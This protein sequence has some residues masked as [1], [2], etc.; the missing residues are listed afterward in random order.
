MDSLIKLTAENSCLYYSLAFINCAIGVLTCVLASVI[1]T[2]KLPERR[3]I[4]GFLSAA[5]CAAAAW[6]RVNMSF[7]E[8]DFLYTFG[9]IL[10]FLL[11]FICIFAFYPGKKCF[12]PFLAAAGLIFTDALKYIV[13]MFLSYDYFDNSDITEL[14][15]ELSIGTA[16]LIVVFAVFARRTKKTNAG[17]FAVKPDVPLYILVLLSVSVFIATLIFFG[18]N[19]SEKTRFSFLLALLNI[20]LVGSTVLYA[21]SKMFR[22]RLAEENYR[23]RLDMQRRHFSQMEKK[24][25]ELRVFRHDFPKKLRPAVMYLSDG[26]TAAAMDILSEFT[27]QI[28]ASR[29]R[30][31]TGNFMLDT[32]LECQQQLAEKSGCSITLAS[33]SIFPP[34]GIEPDD[35][36]TIFPNALDNAIE[37][38]ERQSGGGEIVFASRIAEDTVYVS[39][40]NPCSSSINRN[41]QLETTKAD[42]SIHGLGIK[43]I[44]K[45]AAKYG[46]DNV[47]YFTKDGQFVLRIT[48][49]YKKT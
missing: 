32:V 31:N 12:K 1:V 19:Y 27:K 3:L 6:V 16:V 28:E 17:I 14:F 38:C 21:V 35:I 11:N 5:L 46:A 36:Y 33:G 37:E 26:N 8:A 7:N 4:P 2:K 24:N 10:L 23:R 30:F 42:K 25:E 34:E 39:I 44:K 13:L 49:R 45:A 41:T 43:S 48:L 22:S 15:T 20:P 40:K 47:E 9:I 29:P 18:I